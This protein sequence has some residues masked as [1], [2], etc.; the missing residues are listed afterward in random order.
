MTVNMA[1]Y[2]GQLSQIGDIRWD[3]EVGMTDTLPD[4]S[5]YGRSGVQFPAA[6]FPLAAVRQ[7]MMIN[8]LPSTSATALRVTGWATNGAGTI[9]VAYGN[10]TTV[11]VTTNGGQTWATV[12]HNNA[13]AVTDVAYNALNGRFISVG[14]TAAA[15]TC[16]FSTTPASTWTAGGTSGALTSLSANSARVMSDGAT[17]V[18]AAA[19]TAASTA[20]IATTVDGATVTA[21]TGLPVSL[22]VAASPLIAVLPSLGATRWLVATGV[23]GTAQWNRSSAADGSAWTAVNSADNSNN[24][25]G[26]AAGNGIFISMATAGVYY[27]SP[28]ANTWTTRQLPISLGTQQSDMFNPSPPAG[29]GVTVMASFL[30]GLSFDGTRF[31]TNS[32]LTA[33]SSP[34]GLFGI[35]TDGLTW[36]TR[37]LSYAAASSFGM[38]VMNSGTGLATLNYGNTVS[39]NGA[40]YS[41][42]WFTSCDFVGRARSFQQTVPSTATPMVAYYRIA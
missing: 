7:N 37:Q 30:N 27:T 24:M 35:T 12:N 23:A 26:L 15:I 28:D 6:S 8:G 11:Y 13:N 39:L 42:N 16:S 1:K 40:L 20:Y 32:F 31:L 9:V 34:N 3:T 17:C 41:A 29:A 2:T 10:A 36:I 14:N 25:I 33:A 19:V 18:A 21:R 38:A 4:G 22:S 5:V